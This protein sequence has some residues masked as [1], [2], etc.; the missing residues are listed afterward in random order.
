MSNGYSMDPSN[1]PPLSAR[2]GEIE[3][4]ELVGMFREIEKS[5]T[6]EESRFANKTKAH[7]E[8]WDRFVEQR[9]D[10]EQRGLIPELPFD[11]DIDPGPRGIG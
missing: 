5:I 1:L 4:E 10:A 6:K 7:Q 3:Y 2:E 8:Q 9:R 11:P